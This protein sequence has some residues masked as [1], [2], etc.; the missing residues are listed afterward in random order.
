MFNYLRIGI[1]EISHDLLFE[2]SLT[3]VSCSKA[4]VWLSLNQYVSVLTSLSNFS[5]STADFLLSCNQYE[6]VLFL[7]DHFWT[8]NTFNLYSYL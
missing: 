5:L 4:F 1:S 8:H 7:A 2:T 6:S 3:D